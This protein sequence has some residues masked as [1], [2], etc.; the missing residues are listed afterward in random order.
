MPGF[1]IDC[2]NLHRTLAGLIR[3]NSVN[4]SLV[5]GAAGE[6][7]AAACVKETLQLLGLEVAVREAEPGRPSVVGTLR[8]TGGGRSLMLNGH[9]DTVGTEGMR[10]A[11]APVVRDGRMYGRGAFDMKGGLAAS[12]AAVK[13]LVDTDLA[14]LNKAMNEAG[15]A[16]IAAPSAGGRGGGRP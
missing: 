11:F 3:I 14:A 7:E 16:H 15:V 1:V 13:A 10:D 12:L 9:L 5:P 8:G 2:E 6:G 4:P